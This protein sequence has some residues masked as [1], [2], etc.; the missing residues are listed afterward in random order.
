MH[1]IVATGPWLTWLGKNQESMTGSESLGYLVEEGRIYSF[2][3]KR[4]L[5]SWG[6]FL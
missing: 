6:A 2:L 4:E 5:I 3:D 1:A